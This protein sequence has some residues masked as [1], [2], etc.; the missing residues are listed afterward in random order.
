MTAGVHVHQ[1]IGILPDKARDLYQI[2]EHAEAWTALAIGYQGDPAKLPEALK[3]RDLTL[4]QRKPLGQFVFTG[5]WGQP[6]PVV[7][8]RDA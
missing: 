1:M 2:P 5:Q 7:L 8:K 4:R 3:E 6:S